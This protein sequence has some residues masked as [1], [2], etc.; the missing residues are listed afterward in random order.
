M[1]SCPLRPSLPLIVI[2]Y[3]ALCLFW[4]GFAHLVA[5]SIIAAAYN[6]RSLPVLNQ[7]FQGLRSLPIEHYLHRWSV[8]ATAVLIGT[9]LHL[10]IVLFIKSVDRKHLLLLLNSPR[11]GLCNNFFLI[12]F[13]AAFLAL[14]VLSW[15]QGDYRAYLGEWSVVLEG[16]NPWVDGGNNA[17]GPLFNALGPLVWINPLASKLLFAFS[18][19]VYVIWLVKDFALRGELVARSWPWLSLWLLNPFPWIEI[20]YF[21]YFDVLVGLACVAA[22][23]SLLAKKDGTAGAYLALGV[24]LKFMPIVIVPFLAL[25]ERRLH[26]RLL[27]FCIGIV[28]LGFTVSA[29]IWGTSTFLPL[30]FAAAR[31]PQWSIYSVLGSTDSLLRLFSDSPKYT[32]DWLEK[33]LLATAVLGVFG[34]WCVLRRTGPALSAALAILVTLL[35]YRVGYINYQMVL[36]VL[37]SYW[38]ASEWKQL[39]DRYALAAVLGGYFCVLAILDFVSWSV[40]L[41]DDISITK[42]SLSDMVLIKFLLGCALLVVLATLSIHG[43]FQDDPAA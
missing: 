23:H 12:A 34:W 27:S 36:F 38:I 3:A 2:I 37:I 1:S 11:G 31:T 33:P 30:A 19:L 35:F 32:L 8:T 17:Y 5:P 41:T 24:L 10:V 26:V 9:I 40:Q 28:F 13:S 25:N 42:L 29:L 6:D 4:I 22:I 20:A 18:Y 21:G 14:T 39:I 15:V 16:G 7:V 43:R